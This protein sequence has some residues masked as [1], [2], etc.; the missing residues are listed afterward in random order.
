[1]TLLTRDDYAAFPYFPADHRLHYGAQSDQFGD[2]YLPQGAGPHPVAVLLHGG[3]WRQRFGLE[4]MS[5]L[6]EAIRQEGFAVWNLEYRRLEGA[7]GWPM[8]FQ[9]VAAGADFLRSL[10]EQFDLDLGRAVVAGHSAGGHLA[11]WLACR[12]NIPEASELYAPEPLE[13]HG[14]LSLAGV[15]DLAEGV[16]R[17]IC[18]GACAQLVGGPPE[19]VP[20][21]YSQASPLEL[22]PIR[23]PHSHLVGEEDP[24]VPADYVATCVE[25][26]RNLPLPEG[27]LPNI[28]LE[29]VPNAGHFEVVAPHSST[30]PLIRE[31]LLELMP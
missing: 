24:I 17:D 29:T 11:L 27:S 5:S 6:C 21:R 8:T 28:R 22:M 20:E 13:F 19:E 10:S 26:S 1:M 3:C 9:D 16:R 30:W 31:M 25:R 2:L 23:I 7:G 14:V 4:P 18:F 15:E 12:G